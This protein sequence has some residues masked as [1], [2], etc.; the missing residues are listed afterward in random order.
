MITI[1]LLKNYPDKTP[2]IVD[3]WY[4]T[5]GKKWM[6]DVCLDEVT[7]RFQA[8]L[9]DNLLP[10]TY[11][12]MDEKKPVG[13]CSLR[14]ND[15]IRPDLSPWLGSLAVNPAYQKR[16]IARQLID[17]VKEKASSLGF[18]KLYLFTFDT[19]IADYYTRLGWKRIDMDDYS[20]HSVTVMEIPV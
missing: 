3:I 19:Q 18:Q 16:G 11:L 4:E 13:I 17:A 6:P 20:G 5:L 2:D 7:Q 15:G 8:H 12:A 1:D 10:L 9:N 14:I